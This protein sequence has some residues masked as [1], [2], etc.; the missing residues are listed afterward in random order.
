M[1]VPQRLQIVARCLVVLTGNFLNIVASSSFMDCSSSGFDVP[2]REQ[3][4]CQSCCLCSIMRKRWFLAVLLR[5]GRPV[6]PSLY[7]YSVQKWPEI[8]KLVQIVS[9]LLLRLPSWLA[10]RLFLGLAAGAL[11]A[12]LPIPI[13]V[14]SDKIAFVITVADQ[15]EGM[16]ITWIGLSII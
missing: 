9:V 2:Q 11:V 16:E 7:G 15:R 10:T 1:R 13:S 8:G 4:Q 3:R 14:F 5:K 12:G 6:L